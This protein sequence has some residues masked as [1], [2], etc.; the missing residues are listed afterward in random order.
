MEEKSEYSRLWGMEK[1]SKVGVAIRI[2]FALAMLGCA[3][4]FFLNLRGCTLAIGA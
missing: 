2:V 4:G 1:P 3:I